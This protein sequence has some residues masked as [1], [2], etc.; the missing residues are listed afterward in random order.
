MGLRSKNNRYNLKK[1]YI[2]CVFCDIIKGV[3]NNILL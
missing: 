2:F 3:D 1:H